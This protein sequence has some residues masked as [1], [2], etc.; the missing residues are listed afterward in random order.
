[1]STKIRVETVN[2][3]AFTAVIMRPATNNEPCTSLD[4]LSAIIRTAKTPG[5]LEVRRLVNAEN[6]LWV[7]HLLNLAHVVTV[8]EPT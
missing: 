2:G 7:D 3:D 6:S 4:E 5:W 8:R 1:M